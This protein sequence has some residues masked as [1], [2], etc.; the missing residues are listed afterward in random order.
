MIAIIVRFVLFVVTLIVILS[1]I[2]YNIN[3]H[4]DHTHDIPK[5]NEIPTLEKGKFIYN[6]TCTHCHNSDTS[7]V[8]AVGP[9][10]KPSSQALINLK[11]NEGK[12]PEGYK[13]RRSTNMMPKYKFSKEQLES[14]YKYINEGK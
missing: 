11:V 7:K 12:Y 2:R 5:P 10:L 6:K 1:L 4:K 9:E 14:L 13:P 3:E 8:G